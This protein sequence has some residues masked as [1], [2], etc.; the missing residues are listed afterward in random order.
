MPADRGELDF[1]SARVFIPD[2]LLREAS[3]ALVAVH[4]HPMPRERAAML[5]LTG[6]SKSISGRF[7]EV[8]GTAAAVDSLSEIVANLGLPPE[9]FTP[10]CWGTFD[11]L[12][13]SNKPLDIPW[14][15]DFS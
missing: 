8:A 6:T 10:I 13:H 5:R 3:E 12:L 14:S 4:L 1:Y 2:N 11:S 15:P 9:I 7:V